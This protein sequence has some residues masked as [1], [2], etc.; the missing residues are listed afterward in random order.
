MFYYLAD[1]EFE[2]NNQNNGQ[3]IRHVNQSLLTGN[4]TIDHADNLDEFT[5]QIGVI[6]DIPEDIM[7]EIGGAVKSVKDL[8][9]AW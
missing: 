3:S 1:V 6:P 9:W 5:N 4:S 7:E 8:N 2:A